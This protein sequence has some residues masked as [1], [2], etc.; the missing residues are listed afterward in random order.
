M[1]D[2]RESQLAQ[3]PAPSAEAL[4]LSRQLLRQMAEE[5]E[6]GLLPFDRF[7]ELALYA[8]GLGYY[9]NGLRKFGEGGDFVT[10]PELSP[11]FGRCLARQL[12]EVLDQL[13]GAEVLE[14]GAGSG[15]LALDVLRELQQL[16]QLPRRYAILEL[17][18]PLRE[19]QQALLREELPELMPRIRWLERLPQGFVGVML[20]NE[21]VDAMPVSRFRLQG[22]DP[23]APPLEQYVDLRQDPPQGC[24]RPSQHPGLIGQLADLRQRYDLAEGYESELNLRANAWLSALGQALQAGLLLIID[25]GYSGAEF[26]HPQRH[27][28][29]LICHYRQRVHTDPLLWPGLQDITANVN[30]TA[31]AE[32]AYAAGFDSQAFTSQAYFLLANGIQQLIEPTDGRVRLQDLQAVKRLTLPNDMGERFKVLGLGKGLQ[33]RPRGFDLMRYPLG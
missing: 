3:L 24:W 30:F 10:A 15:R 6:A 14:F 23:L 13:G 29:S 27:Q 18:A 25:Y 5:A 16:G 22:S 28:G 21:V 19:R 31:L 7:M 8:P 11:L 20:A 4:A 32:A 17:S 33:Q 2:P 12:A 1:R 9:A 26:Y